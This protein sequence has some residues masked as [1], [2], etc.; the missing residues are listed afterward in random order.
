MR[1]WIAALA[2]AGCNP[3][4]VTQP[5]LVVVVDTDAPIPR[6]GDRLSVEV[7]DAAGTACASCRRIF[8]VS[9]P[10]AW[11]HSF[12]VA[13]GAGALVRLR[14]Y[15]ARDQ[16]QD[17][18][19]R[20]EKTVD[21]VAELPPAD[22]V[23]TV[24]AT[25]HM[26][27]A[28]RPADPAKRTTCSGPIG[29]LGQARPLDDDPGTPSAAG[30]WP[31]AVTKPCQ[32]EP[33]ADERCMPGGAYFMGDDNSSVDDGPSH[34]VVMKPFF[35]DVDE[36]RVGNFRFWYNDF[37]LAHGGT[38]AFP[39]G[40]TEASSHCTLHDKLVTAAD[41]D[42]LPM[43]CLAREFAA[44]YCAAIGKRLPTEAEWEWAASAGSAEQ[45]FPWGNDPRIHCSE[46][47]LARTP[48][49]YGGKTS[50]SG[51]S[52]CAFPLDLPLAPPVGSGSRDDNG[53]GAIDGIGIR[54]L[55]GSMQEF[56]ADN[57]EPYD[58]PCWSKPGQVSPRCDGP[59]GRDGVRGGSW[60]LGAADAAR[61]NRYSVITTSI[62][63]EIG[64]R[65][66][67]DDDGK[68]PPKRPKPPP[69]PADAICSQKDYAPLWQLRD[70]LIS[71]SGVRGQ[72]YL[73]G[74]AF[75]GDPKTGWQTNPLPEK[76][77]IEIA[78]RFPVVVQEVDP[79]T[80]ATLEEYFTSGR[81]EFY[82]AGE[83]TPFVTTDPS[84]FGKLQTLLLQPALEGVSRV[85]FVG[86]S[87]VDQMPDPTSPATPY[88]GELRVS[89]RCSKSP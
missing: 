13:D 71:A 30:S 5:Q 42:A 80:D 81:V 32:G 59:T 66:A 27:C 88:L 10:K 8:D 22:G 45:S 40:F 60:M 74:F 75:D 83:D 7:L 24:R 37:L 51:D 56:V 44:M 61:S 21:L 17:G 50:A 18:G 62:S 78:F 70:V 20:P 49:G 41:H 57:A 26:A 47:V 31:G 53:V 86:T 29:E 16:T 4:A 46:S 85:R 34:L 14:L 35:L 64:F 58:G 43:N 87:Y 15:R 33:A 38:G 54:D 69:A 11:P 63:H 79:I 82:H 65:C 89:G 39:V 67:R 48:M 76:P 52:S 6:F 73:P 68:P 3:A 23:R 25:L 28:G 36:V 72:A 19:S 1:R 84:P 9:D 2:L 55:G 77:W 12:G